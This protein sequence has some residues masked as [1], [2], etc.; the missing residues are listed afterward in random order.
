MKI[1]HFALAG[2][3]SVALAAPAFADTAAPA[4]APAPAAAPA[5]ITGVPAAQLIARVDIP[6]QEFT[7]PNGLRVIVHTDRKA[8]IVAVS[9]WYNV[10][11]T[12]EPAGRTGFAH[13]FE[14]LMF[15]GSENAPDDF[16]VP[17]KSIGATDLNG[18][19]N[20]DRT[21][22]FETVPTGALDRTLFLESDRMGYLSGAI[23]QS[24]LDEQRGVVQNEKRQGDNQPYGLVQYQLFGGLFPAGTPYGHTVIGSMTDL[25]AAS[26]QTVKD[27]FHD[28]YGPNNAV[29]VLAGDID[30]A[31][32]RT[33]VAKYF[34]NIPRGPQSNFPATTIPQLTAPVSVTIKD[35]VAAVLVMKS[36]PVPNFRD[37]D[38]AALEVA[39]GVLGGLASSRLDNALVKRE[40]LAVQVSAGNNGLRGAGVFQIRAV[41]RPGVD[42]ALVSRRIDEILA[43]F[44]KNGPSADEVNRVVTQSASGTIQGLESVG[45]F[46]GKAVALAQGA[47]FAGDPAYYKKELADL[48]AQ[49]P[50]TVR[51][52]ANR[53]LTRP[54]YTLQV[55]PGAR[56]A[57]AEAAAPAPA[58]AAVA[59]PTPAPKNSRGSLT[60][61]P[62]GELTGLTFPTI[63]RDRLSNGIELVYAQRGAVPVTQAVISFDAGVAAD[64]AGRL[65]TAA[66]TL[67]ML[68]QGAAG[69]DSIAIAEAEER[70][71]MGLSTG[72][73]LDRSTVSFSVPSANLAP[74]IG[75]WSDIVRR[76]DFAD[77][78]VARVKQQQLAGI[79]Q[80]L[81]NPNALGGRALPRLI[82]GAANPYAK[83]LGGGD[84][85]AVAALTPADLTAWQQAWLRPDK[86]KIFVVSDRPLAEIKA[87]LEARFGD[88]AATGTAGTKSF[89][90]ATP[91]APKIVLIDRPDSPQSVILGAIPTSLAGTD[92]LLAVNTA[93]DA[94]GGDFLSRINLD[95]REARHWSYG[96]NGSFRPAEHAANYY[97]SAPVQANQTGPSLASLREDLKA[98]LGAQPMSTVEFDRAVTGSIR[99]LPGSFETSDDVLGAMQ[100]NDLYRRPDDYYARITA[101]YRALTQPQLTT[102]INGAIDPSRAVWVVVGDAKTVK[103]QLDS[104]GLPVE[105]V[106]AASL[107]GAAPSSGQ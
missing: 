23:T 18:T 66:L 105:V 52:A 49:T 63:T 15:N 71:G 87:L 103:P 92:D 25:D 76:P 94:L 53:W 65:G 86:A 26:L 13:L 68:E 90:A 77:A 96:A 2:V 36:W 30:V 74:A 37:R 78:E 20:F 72:S 91:S 29:L 80:E 99:Q 106:T 75:L 43:D 64:V 21:N 7:L 67:N 22:Y 3:A 1:K 31:K 73:S 32:A 85:A 95:L 19:T 104:L 100:R 47:L 28:H 6:Y 83:S 38:A 51:A 98:Y 107:A 88:W 10:G 69:R 54:S 57:Y 60:M 48:A 24:V 4:L 97:I 45:G 62:V 61:P 40:K 34:G 101:R 17:L 41:V 44:L 27:W 39:G 56:E 5:P 11:S 81:T 58:A 84:P 33:L 55:V 93:N 46:G 16:F 79:A 14:H 89:V 70:L 35:R 12:F 50:A 82:Y 42:P 8:P 9:V 59:A 102:A